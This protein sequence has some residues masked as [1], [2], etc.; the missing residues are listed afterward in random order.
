MAMPLA[1]VTR[2]LLAVV[3]PFRFYEC[4][5]LPMGV[6]PAIYDDW[7]VNGPQSPAGT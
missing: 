1:D 2:K 7:A 4:C 5:V 3:M 6:S